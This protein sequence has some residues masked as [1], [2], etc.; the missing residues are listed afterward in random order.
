MLRLKRLGVTGF[1][2]F[3]EE[4]VLELPPGGGVTVVYGEN[5]RGKTS[6]LNAIRYAFLGTVYGRGSRVRNVATITNRD[7]AAIGTYGF[8]VSLVFEHDGSDY[9][10]VRECRPRVAIPTGDDDYEQEVML[11]RGQSV[12]GPGERDHALQQIFPKDISRFF[13]FD[14]ELLQE[15]EELLISGSEAGQKISEHIERIL[16]VPILKKARIH[17]T[18]LSEEADKQAAREASKVQAT[19]G[20]GAALEA[21][22]AQK[23]AHQSEVARF[24]GQLDELTEQ[25]AEI[26]HAM[27]SS[28][29]Y[30]G[31]LEKRDQ[32][33]KRQEVLADEEKKRRAEIQTAM[34][35]A[36]RSLLR[37]PVRTARATA[38]LEAQRELDTFVMSLREKAIDAG[39]CGICDQD[40][41]VLPSA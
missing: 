40:I 19:Q 3:A 33:H 5:M 22:T 25:R 2:P 38:Q 7:R 16:G 11:C 17:L 32:A 27:Q 31:L 20:L 14:G 35:E 15:Y 34:G 36:W 8:S 23:E 1:G 18:R 26:E 29:K 28:Q 12:L 13:L 37:E 41:P 4:Q 9:E 24:Q 6:L 39:H 21:A 30:A 10:L